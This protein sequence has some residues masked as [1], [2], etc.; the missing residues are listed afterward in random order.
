MC[1]LGE[2]E[3]RG[4][5]NFVKNT[6]VKKSFSWEYARGWVGVCKAKKSKKSRHIPG[7][8]FFFSSCCFFNVPNQKLNILKNLEFKY[9]F[10]E[11]IN[12]KKIFLNICMGEGGCWDH[13]IYKKS[14]KKLFFGGCGGVEQKFTKISNLGIFRGKTFF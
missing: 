5:I 12:P 6:G 2:N 4:V 11:K 3:D 13:K 7:E 14:G 10:Y 8:K 1:L 9:L